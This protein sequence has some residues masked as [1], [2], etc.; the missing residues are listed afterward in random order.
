MELR[1][2]GTFV[3]NQTE[4]SWLVLPLTVWWLFLTGTSTIDRL[5]VAT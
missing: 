3:G 4:D 1:G 2:N 5:L